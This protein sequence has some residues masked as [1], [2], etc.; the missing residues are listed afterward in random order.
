[1]ATVVLALIVVGAILLLLETILPGLIAGIAGAFC[2]MAGVVMGYVYFGPDIG[3]WI[4]VGVGA[5]LLAAMAAYA[6]MFP[7]SR[8]AQRFVSQR[9]IGTVGAEKPELVHQTGVAHTHL[10][11]SGTALLNGQRVDVVTEGS[12]IERGTPIK[13]IAVEG[14]RVVVRAL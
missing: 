9:T 12:M 11:P 10:R 8:L 5:G 4:L 7:S 13:V 1:M 6:N 2:L 14:M 3:T